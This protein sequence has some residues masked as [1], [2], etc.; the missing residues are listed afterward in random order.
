M[1]RRRYGKTFSDYLHR[2][3]Y[4]SILLKNCNIDEITSI[5]SKLEISKACGPY[6]IPTNLLKISTVLSPMIVVLINKSLSEGT[7]LSLKRTKFI[8]VK[9]IDQLSSY[10]I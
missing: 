10:Q 4:N 9:I 7:L 3:N 1:L 5:I 8:N 2:P 6:S